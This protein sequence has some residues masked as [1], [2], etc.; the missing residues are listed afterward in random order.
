MSFRDSLTTEFK[1]YYFVDIPAIYK[2]YLSSQVREK[3]PVVQRKFK[4]NLVSATLILKTVHET[5]TYTST[6]SSTP[7]AYTLHP[8]RSKQKRT[9]R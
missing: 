7:L 5:P 1:I 2:R 6:F 8:Q 9:D 4:S 3:V